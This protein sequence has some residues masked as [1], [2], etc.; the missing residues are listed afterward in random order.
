MLDKKEKKI[1]DSNF[2]LLRIISM[3]MIVILH[4]GTHGISNYIEVSSFISGF[5]QEI[6]YLIRFLAIVAVNLYVMISGYYLSKSKFKLSKLVRV[7]FEVA[8]FSSIIYLINVAMGYSEFQILT[9]LD[10]FLA[11]F[12]NEY[13]FVTVYFTLYAF[14]PFLNKLIS[15]LSKKEYLSLLF[16]FFL[17]CCVWQFIIPIETIGVHHGNGLMY[18]VFLYLL[19]GYIQKFDFIIKKSKAKNYVCSYFILA[20]FCTAIYIYGSFYNQDNFIF[21]H[22]SRLDQYN[23]PI[24][25]VMTYSLFQFFNNIKLK[26]KII[27]YVSQFT[28]GI[29]LIHDHSLNREIIWKKLGIIEDIISTNNFMFIVKMLG[30]GIFVFIICW[31]LSYIVTQIFRVLY[32]LGIGKSL[33]KQEIKK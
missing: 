9:L 24:V 29:Y 30:Y 8:F 17:V 6:Y 32:E 12:S 7:F 20:I 19:G 33:L 1:R 15:Q 14:S 31:I 23:S 18:F 11:V 3:F 10:S 25:L 21:T 28:F 16:I 13:W 22:I 5:S 27:N 4:I 26:S 2:E